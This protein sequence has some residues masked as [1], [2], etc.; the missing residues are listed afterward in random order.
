MSKKQVLLL[1]LF[2]CA[3]NKDGRSTVPRDGDARWARS[4]SADWPVPVNVSLQP[5]RQLRAPRDNS[6]TDT[7][8]DRQSS[9]DLER[10]RL[11]HRRLL[12]WVS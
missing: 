2:G 12:Y 7:E 8:A 9:H 10:R 3:Q 6:L 1:S 5:S 4:R 11:S